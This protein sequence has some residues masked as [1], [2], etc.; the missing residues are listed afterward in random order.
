MTFRGSTSAA[1]TQPEI[2]NR[3]VSRLW[4]I[5]IPVQARRVRKME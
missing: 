3:R 5:R 4:C 1:T 2:K